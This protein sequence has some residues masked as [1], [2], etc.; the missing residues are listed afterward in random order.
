MSHG[1]FLARVKPGSVKERIQDW[2]RILI[3]KLLDACKPLV[4]MWIIGIP[5]AKGL[6]KALIKVL[7]CQGMN[8]LCAQKLLDLIVSLKGYYI[9]AAVIVAWSTSP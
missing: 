3:C 6:E 2:K 4:N 1:F 7:F 5:V 8:T 9:K